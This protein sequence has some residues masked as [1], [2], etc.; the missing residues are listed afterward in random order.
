VQ[1]FVGSSIG[2]TSW[3]PAPHDARHPLVLNDVYQK[4]VSAHEVA[5]RFEFQ[6]NRH[7]LCERSLR[8]LR[9][10]LLRL[11]L[12]SPCFSSRS[13]SRS[14]VTKSP[15]QRC[16]HNPLRFRFDKKALK[17]PRSVFLRPR[18]CVSTQDTALKSN[19]HRHNSHRQQSHINPSPQSKIPSNLGRFPSLLILRA[20]LLM[21]PS[22][23]IPRAA[24]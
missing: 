9:A 1:P 16:L 20:A 4:S 22:P 10:R 7:R 23:L 6:S 21:Q 15:P 24:L 3:L 19:F 11:Q 5:I 2:A 17:R 8:I 14:S 12:T 18:S 13:R